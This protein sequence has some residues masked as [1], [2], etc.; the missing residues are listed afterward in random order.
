M[1]D[2]LNRANIGRPQADR[3][4]PPSVSTSDDAPTA[5]E[6]LAKLHCVLDIRQQLRDL[7]SRPPSVDRRHSLSGPRFLDLFY[8]QNVPVVLTDVADQ[9][10]AVRTWSADYLSEV[11]EDQPVEVMTG[12]DADPKFE[13]NWRLHRTTM[14]FSQFVRHV[15]DAAPSNDQY[16]VA[17]NRFL[18]AVAAQPLWNDFSVDRR[19]LDNRQI[20][21]KVS[22]WFGPANTVTPLHHDLQNILF[23]QVHGRKV[24]RLVSPLESHCVYNRA[25]VYSDVDANEPDLDAHPDFARVFRHTVTLEPGNALFLPVG[26]W[27]HVTALDTSISLSFTNFRWLN[28]FEWYQPSLPPPP[29]RIS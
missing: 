4:G 3:T 29:F 26:W 1:T 24:L 21:G 17:N 22:L 18:E 28:R 13:M 2:S 6:Q 14:P 10:P 12:R 9:W 20:K 23:V 5:A 19:Y 7:S 25:A 27:H 8:S 11:L 16:L 15:V